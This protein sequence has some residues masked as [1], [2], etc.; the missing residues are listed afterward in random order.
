MV[1][2]TFTTGLC[3]ARMR[4]NLAIPPTIFVVG[5]LLLCIKYSLKCV[6]VVTILVVVVKRSSVK[7]FNCEGLVL[8]KDQTCGVPGR[9]IFKN[10]M[11]I[12]DTIS[13]IQQKQLSAAII[14]LDQEKA[15]DHTA[16]LQR[17]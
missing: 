2:I 12:P 10:L 8:S 4:L 13:F 1:A 14:S 17:V 7:C 3:T 11:L 6:A 9:T 5:K 16:F 15:F